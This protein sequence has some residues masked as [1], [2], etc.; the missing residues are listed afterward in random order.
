MATR[1]FVIKCLGCNA[2]VTN[3]R[4]TC[5]FCG[6][7][8]SM[9]GLGGG[10]ASGKQGH[11]TMS[12]GAHVVVGAASGEQRDCPHCGARVSTKDVNCAQCG[13]AV[14]LT[15]LWLRKLVIEKGASLTVEKGGKVMI[16]RPGPA[17][18]L[19]RAATMG[20]LAQVKER[21]RRQDDVDATGPQGK[22]PLILSLESGHLEVARYLIAMGATLDDADEEGR[23]PLHVAAQ[24][25]YG[26][27][28]EV[29][30]REG[31][32][33]KLATK[34]GRKTPAQLAAEAGHVDLATRLNA[35]G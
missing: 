2:P 19:A 26:E 18:G 21:L 12:A 7:A 10:V 17:P 6:A 9:D 27:L 15:S 22:T 8:V 3:V 14:V 30:L 32:R 35:A 16:G 25:G 11:V 34:K 5:P 1:R 29:L 13:E 23:T 31:A 24:Q 4:R 20:D 28:V 33:P